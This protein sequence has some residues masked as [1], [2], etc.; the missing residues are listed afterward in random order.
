MDKLFI[1]EVSL[2]ID[3]S[4]VVSSD[5]G[6]FANVQIVSHT[7]NDVARLHFHSQIDPVFLAVTGQTGSQ[8]QIFFAIECGD[9]SGDVAHCNLAGDIRELALLG[10]PGRPKLYLSVVEHLENFEGIGMQIR[11]GRSE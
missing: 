6:I 11:L 2:L 10:L 9:D 4:G 3:I 1:L 7:F 5:C 8:P